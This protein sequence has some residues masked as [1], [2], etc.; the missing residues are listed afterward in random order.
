M[1][2]LVLAACNGSCDRPP[3]G[4]GEPVTAASD[5]K[6][7]DLAPLPEPP[8]LDIEPEALPGAEGAL[9]VMV[10][11]PQGPIQ[12]EVRPTVTFSRPVKSLGEVEDHRDADKQK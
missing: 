6:G 4:N 12:G 9:A 1:T 7:I 11:R 5:S 3:K 10:A 2:A 8:K